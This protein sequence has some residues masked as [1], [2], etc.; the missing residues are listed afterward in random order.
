VVAFGTLIGGKER[1]LEV[2]FPDICVSGVE[3]VKLKIP[4]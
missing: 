3:G 4:D 2:V 1:V